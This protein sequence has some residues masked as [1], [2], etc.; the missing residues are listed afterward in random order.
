VSHLASSI[1]AA[2]SAAATLRSKSGGRELLSIECR[3][4]SL[5][6][7]PAA[8]LP[9]LDHNVLLLKSVAAVEILKRDDE[10]Q[11]ITGAVLTPNVLDKQGDRYGAKAVRDAAH[12]YLRDHRKVRLMHKQDADDRAHIVESW[13]APADLTIGGHAVRE[14]SWIVTM[15][16]VDPGLWRD[17]RAGRVGGFSIGGHATSR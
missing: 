11:T 5:V 9:G 12:A 10:E 4:I 15:K 13:L 17:V 14:G 8:S 1:R 2:K 16:I 6:D 3:E 7:R